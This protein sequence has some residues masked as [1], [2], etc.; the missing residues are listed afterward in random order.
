MDKT[1]L[2]FNQRNLILPIQGSINILKLDIKYFNM[3]FF[4]LIPGTYES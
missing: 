1:D 4:F 3:D 2:D